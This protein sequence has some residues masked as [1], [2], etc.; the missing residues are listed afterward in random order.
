[1]FRPPDPVYL[2]FPIYRK[3]TG[4]DDLP[5]ELL[6]NI[7]AALTGLNRNRDLAN[8]ALV[9]QKWRSIAQEWL[10]KKPRFNITYIDQYMWELSHRPELLGQVKDLEIWSTS[11]GRIQLDED[12][13]PK[14]EYTKIPAPDGWDR[15]F[16]AKC[17]P[18]IE[19]FAPGILDQYRWRRALEEDVVPAL[20][21]V[22]VCMLPN[23]KE[24]KLGGGWLM[25]FPI[26]STMLSH[27]VQNSHLHSPYGWQHEFLAGALAHIAPR[28]EVLEV[29]ADMSTLCFFRA[30]TVFDFSPF[31]Q[32]KEIGITMKA[33][34]HSAGI[35]RHQPGPREVLPPTLEVLRISEASPYT[36]IF[37]KDL[38]TVK[39][40][41]HFPSLR[42]VEVYHLETMRCNEVFAEKYQCP[43]PVKYMQDEFRKAELELYVYF[44]GWGELR[45]WEIGGTPWRL[46][47]EGVLGEGEM[48]ALG[49]LLEEHGQRFSDGY[50]DVVAHAF[51][52]LE[53]EW[54]ADGD[55]VM[56]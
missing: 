9:S 24:L 17:K 27:E 46:R 10:L 16:K 7:G 12:G 13:R 41:G 21:G 50:L 37:L 34:W 2:P 5:D 11:E 18:V 20:F 32:L 38:C 56:I 22:L 47:E 3:P 43:K 39:K 33:L 42:R 51:P 15:H 44:P 35:R 28:L 14:R 25:D 55:A 48:Q 4:I 6:L 8:L 40:G 52:G 23:L 54:D 45:T 26:F 53:A 29:A 31:H 1:M 36:P 19:K 49:K 30:A